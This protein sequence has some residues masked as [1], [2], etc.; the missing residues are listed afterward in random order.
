MRLAIALLALLS[1]SAFAAAACSSYSTCASCADSSDCQWCKGTN[2]C[3]PLSA[4]EESCA[5]NNWAVITEQCPGGA[6][7]GTSDACCCPA[8]FAIAALALGIAA[9]RRE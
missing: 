8:G 6:L 9:W 5:G 4:D 3:Y 2:R 7:A 1:I